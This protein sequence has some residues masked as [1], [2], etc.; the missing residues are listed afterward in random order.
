MLPYT[1]STF[2]EDAPAPI[3]DFGSGGKVDLHEGLASGL[4]HDVSKL[5]GDGQHAGVIYKNILILGSSVSES[6]DAA[7]GHIRAFDVV[8]GKLLWTFHT[9]PQPG[10][11]L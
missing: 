10:N 8:T 11:W 1:A 4:D 5:I 7:P 9:V 3:P 6:G 2:E